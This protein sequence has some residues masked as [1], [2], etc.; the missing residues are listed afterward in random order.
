MEWWIDRFRVAIQSIIFFI[1]A[2]IAPIRTAMEVLLVVAT[3]DFFAG[4]AGN[5]W[6]GKE[7]FRIGKAFG[8]MYKMLAYLLLVIVAHFATNHLGE[9]EFATLLTKYVTLLI[10]YWYFINILSNLKEAFPRSS[11]IA[12]LYL[13]ASLKILPLIAGKMGLGGEDMQELAD[14]ARKVTEEKRGEKR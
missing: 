7:R 11:G 14:K 1:L 13:L 4:L 12:F 8:S 6:T 5:V 2:S 3:F 10:I 9:A